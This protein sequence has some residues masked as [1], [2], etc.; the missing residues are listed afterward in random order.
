V[1]LLR[2]TCSDTDGTLEEDELERYGFVLEPTAQLAT[3]FGAQRAMVNAVSLQ[4]LDD[5]QEAPVYVFGYLIGNTDWFLVTAD[6]DD[7]CSHN[8]NPFDIGEARYYVPHDLDLSG[9]VNASY[10]EPDGSFRIRNATKRLNRGSCAPPDQLK[11]AIRT[12]G[13]ARRCIN[14]ACKH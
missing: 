9:L 8:A 12:F 10:A 1:R 13:S 14:A 3:R 4:S 6:G 5:E 11:D 7:T 2:T